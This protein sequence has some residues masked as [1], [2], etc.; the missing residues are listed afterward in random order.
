[1]SDGIL[2]EPTPRSRWRG[3]ALV[4]LLVVT[5]LGVRVGISGQ[6]ALA[7]GEAALERGEH[8]AAAL[9]FRQALSW[10]LPWAAPWRQRATDAL[11]Q[12]AKK[13]EAARDLE[14]AVTTLSAL[15]SGILASWSLVHPDEQLKSRT[16]DK[17]AALLARWEAQRG[18]PAGGE[19]LAALPER[20]AF[21]ARAL[22]R[23]HRPHR[24]WS[25]LAGLGFLLWVGG[26]WRASCAQR[27][28]GRRWWLLGVVGFACF[29]A[30][31]ALG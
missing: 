14:G 26:L 12:L 31:L 20:E 16:D 18:A 22:V 6:G 3:W 27:T 2:S 30:G 17:L 4:C 10:T 15:R 9:A 28:Q 7:R 1:M 29:L 8:L 19:P 24:G 23:D 25:V 21:F 5:A 11:E 13:Q